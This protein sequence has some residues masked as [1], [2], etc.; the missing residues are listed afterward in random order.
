MAE[1]HVICDVNRHLY[2]DV[3][4]DY[5]RIR[6]DIY[7]GERRWLELAKPDQR[8]EQFLRSAFP[9]FENYAKRVPR[10]LPR[11]TP[12]PMSGDGSFSGT[13]YCKHREYNSLLGACAVYSVLVAV[14][15]L[16]H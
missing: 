11:L 16:R 7:V 8:E 12:A 15:C 2:H 13:L 10:L 9:A 4:E 5:W 14:L 3:L 6:H 1:L